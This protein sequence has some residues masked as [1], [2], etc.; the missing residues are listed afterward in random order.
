MQQQLK[1]LGFTQLEQ[2]LPT[3]FETARLEQWTYEQFLKR[4]IAALGTRMSQKFGGASTVP[5][6]FQ[7]QALRKFAGRS[8]VQI[9]AE[10]LRAC[11]AITPAFSSRSATYCMRESMD[12]VSCI[13]GRSTV[14]TFESMPL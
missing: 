5:S 13:P 2:A 10:P 9:M 6:V 12:R 14:S 8:L 11:L 7:D 3:L 1:Q 4:A